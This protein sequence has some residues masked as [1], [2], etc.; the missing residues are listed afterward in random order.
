M[1]EVS[2]IA[3]TPAVWVTRLDLGDPCR[4]RS[5]IGLAE[6]SEYR[7]NPSPTEVGDTSP[8]LRTHRPR[9]GR[10]CG[11]AGVRLPQHRLNMAVSEVGRAGG[12][13][14]SGGQE[15]SRRSVRAAQTHNWTT[16]RGTGCTRARSQGLLQRCTSPSR[17]QARCHPPGRIPSGSWASC[18]PAGRPAGV[19]AP[20][21]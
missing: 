14:G 21:R 17:R 8:S 3:R 9:P 1:A 4:R 16:W 13:S 19:R 6:H 11:A 20:A 15:M 5:L 12:T 18:C 7:P 10:Q 2:P